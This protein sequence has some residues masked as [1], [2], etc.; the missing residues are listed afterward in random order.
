MRTTTP[1]MESYIVHVYRHADNGQ[2]IGQLE[3]PLTGE[4]RTFRSLAQLLEL[5][6]QQLG[7][8]TE[9]QP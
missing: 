8:S 4:R 9:S 1:T 2:V 7:T 3:L 6:R 5:L